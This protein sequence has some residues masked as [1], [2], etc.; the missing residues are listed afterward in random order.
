MKHPLP[1]LD[2]D[3]FCR[4]ATEGTDVALE[5]GVLEALH[6]HYCELG[7]WAL[8]LSL[9]GSGTLADAVERHYVE[10][11]E[12]LR[13]IPETPGVCVDVGSGAG[14]PGFVLAAA[15]PTWEVF[16]IEARQGKWSFLKSASRQT[17]VRVSCLHHRVS[18]RL[19]TTLPEEINLVTLRALRLPVGAWSALLAR[20]AQDGRVLIWMGGEKEAGGDEPGPRKILSSLGF[21][22]VCRRRLRGS[23]RRQIVAFG[24]RG[25]SVA[26]GLAD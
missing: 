17:G 2:F 1:E 20:M 12:G 3:T 11:L 19:P 22:E 14:F 15:L 26:N 10:S 18:D 13:L 8:S 5:R 21:E 24:R 6:G 9:I 4:R 16:L 23:E 25:V 7:R